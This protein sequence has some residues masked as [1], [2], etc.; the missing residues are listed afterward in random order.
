M[1]NFGSG[2][3]MRSYSID[4]DFV[5]I[6]D[7]NK[8]GMYF[9]FNLIKNRKLVRYSEV[10]FQPAICFPAFFRDIFIILYLKTLTR[11]ITLIILSELTYKNPLFK[12]SFFRY[13]FL[14]KCKLFSSGPLYVDNVMIASKLIAPNVYPLKSFNVTI[15]PGGLVLHIGYL[16]KIKG[17][18]EFLKASFWLENRFVAIGQKI[19]KVKYYNKTVE[20]IETRTKAQFFSQIENVAT[21]NPILCF[22]YMAKF[23]LSP[24]L[25][26]EIKSLGIPIVVIR[27]SNA[28]R[29][30]TNYIGRE[31]FLRVDSI[32]KIASLTIRDLKTVALYFR[33]L[34]LAQHYEKIQKY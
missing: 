5:D 32:S 8:K 26:L 14:R 23:D 25:L 2:E 15:D 29:I 9:I 21:K 10:H 6:I 11:N 13:L 4:K 1:S 34:D 12:I 16:S 22:L 18:D 17:F 19:D 28:E 3:F 7:Y 33:S 20:I 27:G 30:L 31:C 24:L